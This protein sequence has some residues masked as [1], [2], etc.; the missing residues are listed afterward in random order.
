[1]PDKL[2]QRKF[3]STIITSV[4]II[5]FF[6]SG[7]CHRNSHWV[8]QKLEHCDIEKPARA[9]GGLCSVPPLCISWQIS[10]ICCPGTWCPLP[11]GGCH[12]NALPGLCLSLQ[13]CS[14]SWTLCNTK[15]YKKKGNSYSEFSTPLTSPPTG[16]ANSYKLITYKNITVCTVG[17]KYTVINSNGGGRARGSAG[18]GGGGWWT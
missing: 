15:G 17:N 10:Q 5:Y 12:P 4:H 3:H 6:F 8:V 7:F 16:D 1:M 9:W 2:C 11:T 18:G 13:L 14:G